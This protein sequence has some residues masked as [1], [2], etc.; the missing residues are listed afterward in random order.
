MDVPKSKKFCCSCC[1]TMAK[2]IPVIFILCILAWSY[3]AYVYHLCLNQ[4]K[5]LEIRVPFLLIY[6][7]ILVFF[8]WSYF[9]TIFTEPGG[10]PQKVISIP[11]LI[12]IPVLI[13]LIRK[14][15]Y[16]SIQFKLSD[17]VFE[18]FNNHP[19]DLARQSIVLR[20]F[21]KDLPIMTFTNSDENYFSDIRYCDKCRI[22]KPDRAHHCSV[23]RKCVL[24]MDHHC[25]WVNNC[26]SYSNYKYF[27]LFLAYGLLMC[28][29]VASTTVQFVLKFWDATSDMR[30]QG[31]SYKIHIIFLF[32]IASMFSISL[33]SLLAYHIYLVSKNRTTLE[34][35]RPPKF[36]ERYDKNGFNLGC[37]N[38]IQE[39]FGREILLWPFPLNTSLGNGVSFPINK[40]IPEAQSLLHSTSI[41]DHKT[42]IDMESSQMT[43]VLSANSSAEQNIRN[44]VKC[45]DLIEI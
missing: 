30:L 38:N 42:S 25:P 43:S 32:F 8:L 1:V 36:M 34:S 17:E 45:Q 13:I 11:R 39:V 28:I 22:V 9:K 16:I 24:K 2:S 41:Y 18:E 7:I 14:L 31:A 35:F 21:S 23:C 26:V 15:I 29:Y 3:Y 44:H 10:A 40:K 27:I 37:F 12:L 4:I 33:F 6:H 19:I 5:S 20:E